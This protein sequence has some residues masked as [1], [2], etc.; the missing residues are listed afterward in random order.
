MTWLVIV[1]FALALPGGGHKIVSETARCET[2]KCVDEL[3][4]LA[5]QDPFVARV[6]IIDRATL[7]IVRTEYYI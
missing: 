3:L 7:Q 1:T 6:V 4:D 2:Q 5:P